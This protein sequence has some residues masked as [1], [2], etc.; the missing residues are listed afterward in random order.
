M[1]VVSPYRQVSYSITRHSYDCCAVCGG[2]FGDSHRYAWVTACKG[3]IHVWRCC[4]VC[5]ETDE[6]ICEAVADSRRFTK[7][8]LGL[9][10]GSYNGN[11][12]ACGAV[13]L[14]RLRYCIKCSIAKRMLDR[15]SFESKLIT[16]ALRELNREIRAQKRANDDSLTQ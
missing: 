9:F 8:A 6:A 15:A 4:H 1:E 7:I 13:S 16:K 14:E 12:C 5:A 3:G 10:G 2:E 11:R